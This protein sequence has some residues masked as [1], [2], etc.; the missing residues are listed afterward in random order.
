MRP[1]HRSSSQTSADLGMSDSH[2]SRDFAGLT[3]RLRAFCVSR[4][5]QSSHTP[6]NLAVSLS[7]EVGELLEYFQ[8]DELTA[9]DRKRRPD[10]HAAAAEEIADVVIYAVQLADAL[11]LDLQDEIDAKIEKNGRR[12]PAAVR[13]AA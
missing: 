1:M 9:A 7:V 6:R 3:R 4:G 8:W 2:R 11:G 5:W 12:F 13:S 10:L